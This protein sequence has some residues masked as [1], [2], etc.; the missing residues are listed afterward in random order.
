MCHIAPYIG[1]RAGEREK[2]QKPLPVLAG[3]DS[4]SSKHAIYGHMLAGKGRSIRNHVG[5]AS[6]GVPART[7]YMGVW[8]QGKGRSFIHHAHGT[9]Q[10]REF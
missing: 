3:Q 7:P 5:G 9:N 1:V 6:Q 10:N 2:F 4:S 8:G